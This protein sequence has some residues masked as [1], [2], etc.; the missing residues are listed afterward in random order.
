MKHTTRTTD[1]AATELTRL[2]E[3]TWLELSDERRAL[4]AP[5]LRALVADFARLAA[6]DRA[7]LVEPVTTDWLVRSF[8]RAR[9]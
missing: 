7:D 5:K 6:L 3:D 2:L 9:G 4:L 8:R 1:P